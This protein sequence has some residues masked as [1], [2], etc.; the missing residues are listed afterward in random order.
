MIFTLMLLTA[1]PQKEE[2]NNNTTNNTT[3]PGDMPPIPA[4]SYVGDSL[5]EKSEEITLGI[6]KEIDNFSP[7]VEEIKEVAP[8]VGYYWHIYDGDQPPD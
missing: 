3:L 4:P 2:D 5:P 1:C 8:G 7:Y 6:G